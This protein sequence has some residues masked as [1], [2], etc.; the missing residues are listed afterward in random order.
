[1]KTRLIVTVLLFIFVIG[2][3][4]RLYDSVLPERM[5]QFAQ[6]TFVEISSR[7]AG[8]GLDAIDGDFIDAYPRNWGLFTC[9]DKGV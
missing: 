6:L 7:L 4:E 1:M 2:D 3:D 9:W 5:G 8:V